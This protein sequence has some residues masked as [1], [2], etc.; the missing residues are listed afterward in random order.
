MAGFRRRVRKYA[1]KKNAV[2]AYKFGRKHQGTAVKAFKLAKKVARMVNVEYKFCDN[3]IGNQLA[4]L[5]GQVRVLHDVDKGT[6]AQERTGASIKT[7]RLSG[8]IHLKLVAEAAAT[9][10]IVLFRGKNENYESYAVGTGASID[11]GVLNDSNV[12]CFLARKDDNNMFDTKF[13]HDKTYTL[14]REGRNSMCLNWNFKLFGH[15]QYRLGATDNDKV[16]NGGLYMMI[17]AD[18]NEVV[19]Y[20][21]NLK[22]AYTD[23]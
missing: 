3:Q 12:A 19:N 20:S 6:G 1:T 16:E 14:S 9:V 4:T 10:R 7:I 17:M 11:R 18:D 15:V 5:G 8:K 23:N 2:A 13:L 22:L 21:Y